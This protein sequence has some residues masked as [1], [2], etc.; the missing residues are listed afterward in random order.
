MVVV[1]VVSAGGGPATKSAKEPR[2][3]LKES[4]GGIHASFRGKHPRKAE[5]NRLSAEGRRGAGAAD[6]VGSC[7]IH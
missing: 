3:P 1:S 7:A 2:T 5:E 6:N 4:H